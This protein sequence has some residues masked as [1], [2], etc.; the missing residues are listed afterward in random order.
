MNAS[1]DY[2]RSPADTH[3]L[4]SRYALRLVARLNAQADGLP[5]DVQERLRFARQQ[6]LARA[7]EARGAAVAEA[8]GVS[9]AGALLL[10]SFV[11]WMQRAASVLPLLLLIGGLLLIQQWSSRE[12]VLAAA[13]VDT[14]LLADTLPPSAY[15]DPGFAEF[16]RTP[17]QP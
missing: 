5:V 7:C 6:A 10:G 2:S 8:V 13:E 16:L 9:N 11:P 12:R 17:P 15:G 3:A 14:L 1:Q 4:E